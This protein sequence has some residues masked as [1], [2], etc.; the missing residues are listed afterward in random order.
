MTTQPSKLEIEA[1]RMEHFS[2][3][4]WARSQLLHAEHN[5]Y[6]ARKNHGCL[7]DEY[8]VRYYLTDVW[9]KQQ[10]CIEYE[11]KYPLER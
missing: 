5:L 2:D 4:L 7:S 11:L 1:A 3:L 9:E 6:R 10:A 8:Y